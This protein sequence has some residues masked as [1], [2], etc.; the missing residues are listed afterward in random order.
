MS[1]MGNNDIPK[2]DLS[3]L[4]ERHLTDFRVVRKVGEGAFGIVYL[5]EKKGAVLNQADKFCAIKLLKLWIMRDEVKK[6]LEKRFFQEYQTG[7]IDSNFLVHSYNYGDLDGIP[8]ITMEWCPN[9]N[10]R[11]V[12]NHK[13]EISATVTIAKNILYGLKDLHTNGRVHRDLKP[14]NILLDSKKLAKL[15]DFGIVGHFNIQSTRGEQFINFSN[16]MLGTNHYLPPEQ[17]SKEKRTESILPMIDIYA[18]GVICYELFS[19]GNLPYGKWHMRSDEHVY[20]DRAL[21]G[22]YDLLGEEV[23][24]IWQQIIYKAIHPDQNIRQKNAEEILE[25]VEQLKTPRKEEPKGQHIVL[26][27]MQGEETGKEFSLYEFQQ[28]AKRNT[29]LV[30]RQD[31]RTN[32]D[33][34]IKEIIT[35]HISRSHFTL[36]NID[37]QWYVRDGQW[38]QS[39]KRWRSSTNGTYVNGYEM[40]QKNSPHPLRRGDIITIG[41]TTL[42]II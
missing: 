11:K 28:K 15:S 40:K 18:F 21:R 26:K 36:E 22:K 27:V 7:L 25:Q 3:R 30:G 24:R 38:D 8:F 34:A 20:I 35:Q 42:K 17:F 32:N 37:N 33:I 14:E 13:P 2:M 12:I 6:Q 10:L 9:D 41:N 5:L 39:N 29:L 4:I 1:A 19:G 16:Q 31:V 23:P